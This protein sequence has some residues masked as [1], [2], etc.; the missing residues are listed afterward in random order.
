MNKQYHDDGYS[1]S[2]QVV[3]DLVTD[4]MSPNR[5]KRYVMIK[6][7]REGGVSYSEY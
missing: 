5:E 1:S 3:H 4:Y 6:K 2:N 7:E